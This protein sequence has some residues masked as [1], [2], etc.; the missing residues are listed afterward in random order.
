MFKKILIAIL[1]VIIA[2]V[3]FAAYSG[4]F[5]K[6]EIVE[7]EVGPYTFIG[8]EYVGNYKNSGI[9]QDSIYNDLISKNLELEKGFG[10]YRDDPEQVP[11]DECRFMVGCVLLDKDTIRRVELK[12]AGYIIQ[13]MNKTNSMVVEFPFKNSFSIIASVMKVYPALNEYIKEKGYQPAESL[14]IYTQDKI[15]ISIE[16]KK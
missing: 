2:I 3:G 13:K 4:F 9:Y 15:Y 8:K 6:V 10:I 11:E 7:K 1:V 16:I 5:A 14:E 12:K